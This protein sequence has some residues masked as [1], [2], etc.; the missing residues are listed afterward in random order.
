MRAAFRLRLRI[1][2]V[3]IA[4]VALLILTRLY[5]VQIVHGEEYSLKADRQYVSSGSALFDRG[6]IYFTRKDGALVSAATLATG[7]VVTINPK[8]LTDREAAYQTIA[9]IASSTISREAFM[10]AAANPQVVY[11]EVAH[12]L[13]EAVGKALGEKKIPGVTVLRERWRVYPGGALAA[14]TIGAV[15][16]SANDDVL[17][18]RTGIEARY[19]DTLSRSGDG[20]YK[21]FFAEL[22]S[23]LGNALVSARDARQGDVVTTLEPE[24]ETRLVSNVAKVQTKYASKETGGIIMD[25]KTGAII[26]MASVPSY[27]ANDFSNVSTGTL[28]NPLVSHV[29]EFGSIMK[30]LTMAAALDAGVVTPESTYNDKGCITLD[31]STICNFDLKARG[32]VS[33]QQ[34]LSQ[35]LNLGAAHLASKLG[36]ERF[37]SYFSTLGFGVKTG[38]DLPAEAS[39][40][41]GNLQSPR[42]IEYATAAFGQGVAITPLAMIRA[43]GALA[44]GGEIAR[45]HV[46]SAVQLDSGVSKSLEWEGSM[47]VFS[48]EAARAV[49]E[50]LT[51]VVDHS[52]AHGT[53]TIPTLSVAAKTGTAQLP[54]P[55]GGYYDN[56]YFHSF[57]GY[58]PSYAPRFIILLYTNDPQGVEYASETLTATFMD[59]VHFLND[60]YDLPPDRLPG[61]GEGAPRS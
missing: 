20:L 41:V 25:P 60:Y 3:G 49:S 10:K 22:F 12:H 55:D 17:K 6:S 47:R 44:N 39:G 52:L 32:V 58:F 21:N 2:L 48:P 23:N 61:Q 15:A 5:F 13:P 16:Y 14:Q 43:L 51:S 11:V 29:Y 30:A 26:A 4:L 28:T 38:I 35:S 18:G 46:G 33:M 27:D 36:P 34:I 8:L 40:L 53:L 54:A 42:Q 1:V 9:G 7:F 45:P 19:E 31:T 24:V 50:M 56:R 59:L 37:R 57:F